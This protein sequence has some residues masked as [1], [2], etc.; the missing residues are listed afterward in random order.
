VYVPAYKNGTDQ[1]LGATIVG[2]H[3][4]DMISEITVAMQSGMGLGK[5]ANEIHPIPTVVEAIHQCGDA[6]NRGRLM[7]IVIGI[8]KRLMAFK[9]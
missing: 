9:R 6:Y 8:F 7:P 5:L 4:G 3:A 1:I 2:S